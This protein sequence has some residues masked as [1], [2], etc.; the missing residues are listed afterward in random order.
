MFEIIGQFLT[1][2][3]GIIPRL[4]IVR[5][6]HR[7]IKFRLGKYPK[8][9]KPGLHF[10]WPLVSQVDLMVVA[11]QTNTLAP[12]VLQTQD[13][14]SVV[15]TGF[16]VFFVYDVVLAAGE[17]NWDAD[18]TV[19]DITRSA[20]MDIVSSNT[21]EYLARGRV[22]KLTSRCRAALKQFGIGVKRVGFVDFCQCKVYRVV[23]GSQI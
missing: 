6:T 10:Y 20:I 15:A 11:R 21:Y 22:P 19:N 8:E 9:L 13:G 14:K 3:L 1:A 4:V 5:A 16:I 12:Q 23:G 7:G 18:T 2:I 17:K